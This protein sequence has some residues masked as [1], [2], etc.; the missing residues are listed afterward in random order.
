MSMT[1]RR[2]MNTRNLR[3]LARDTQAIGK[4]VK[5]ELMQ[6]HK[7]IKQNSFI[8]SAFLLVLYRIVVSNKSA[9]AAKNGEDAEH[10]KR[11]A[12]KTSIREVGGFSLSYLVFRM[13]EALN[14]R[15]FRK[16]FG[17]AEHPSI[18]RSARQQFRNALAGQ[19]VDTIAPVQSVVA[20]DQAV[21]GRTY[22]DIT[23]GADGAAGRSVR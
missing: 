5:H 8:M 1:V 18:L 4:N 16:L 19:P 9:M 14:K 20:A 2:L 15:F 3:Q 10:R 6:D 12:I 21:A 17:A 11:E 13:V 7:T 23:R 22:L